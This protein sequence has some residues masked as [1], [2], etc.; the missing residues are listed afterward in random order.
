MLDPRYVAEHLEEVR[1]GLARRG[2]HEEEKLRRLAELVEARRSAITEEEAARAERNRRSQDMARM[3]KGSEAFAAERAK[4]K[5]LSRRV[6]ELERRRAESED[7]LQH[8]L[9]EVPNLPDPSVPEG[10]TEED[11]VEVRRWGER[12]RFDFEP[13]DH[14][15]LGRRLGI[16]DFERAAKVS[17]SRF[18]VL[19]GAG[20]RLERALMQFMLDLH[21]GEHGYE[22]IWPPVL[23]RDSA[24]R[25]TGQLPKFAADAFRIAEDWDVHGETEGHR[26][27]LAP[28][29][30]VPVTNLHAEEI[31]EGGTLPI[32]YAA[33]T[34]CFR[35]EAG[36]Y[37]R[38]TRG[39]IRQHQFDKVELVRFCTPEQ[40]RQQHEALT[41]HAE[42]VLKR[43]EL[44]YRVV[45]L[46]AGELGFAARKAYDLE[47]WLPGQGRFR[48]ISSCS[49]FG[50]YQ[51]RRMRCRYRP[52]PKGRP[53]LLHTIN[54]SGLAI[55][56]TLV[57]LLEQHQDTD[58][59]VRIPGAL[60]PYMGGLERIEPP[61]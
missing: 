2:F 21:T 16:L 18:V 54:G 31:L 7:A 52:E 9:L 44:H 51:A 37:G 6:K 36:S 15:E 33:Y 46:C 25:G 27:Y 11:N 59:S 29:A 28:T 56:R 57:A 48:E 43:L 26:L 19:R 12:P 49:W 10:L 24:M 8:L 17:G 14:V 30:E 60:R 45:E 58:G 4:L 22:E 42:E 1:A 50:D 41:C 23:V 55:G 5:E 40:A 47:V 38:D 3:D 34:A 20:A 39:M 61:A 13:L 35:S 53:R 32:A